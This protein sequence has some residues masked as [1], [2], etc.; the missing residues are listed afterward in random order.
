MDDLQYVSFI[1]LFMVQSEGDH[2]FNYGVE[3]VFHY[4]DNSFVLGVD[5]NNSEM[6]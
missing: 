4:L 3:C 6:I 5:F 2:S 1:W